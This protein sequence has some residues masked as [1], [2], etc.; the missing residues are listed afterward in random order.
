MY[1]RRAGFHNMKPDY[2]DRG[3]HGNDK[4]WASF[5]TAYSPRTCYQNNSLL[6][7]I[8]KKSQ[9]KLYVSTKI[10]FSMVQNY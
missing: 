1:Q 10:W 2:K 3:G 4:F 6:Y 9:L 7:A 5:N 8:Y